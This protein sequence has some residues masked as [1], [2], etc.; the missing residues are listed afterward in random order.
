[1]DPYLGRKGVVRNLRDHL[2]EGKSAIVWGGPKIGKTTFLEQMDEALSPGI[3]PVRIDLA[4]EGTSDPVQSI[5]DGRDPVILLLDNCESLLPDPSTCI[6]R[7]RG[8]TAE[9]RRPLRGIVW[10]GAL[11]WG[12]WAMGHR[13]QF[14]SA[15]RYYPLIV[16]PPREAAVFLKQHLPEDIPSSEQKR[17]LDLTG[18]HPYLLSRRVEQKEPDCS[19]FFDD[20]WKA[21]DRPADHYVL[22][23]LMEAGSWVFLENL[24]D[25]A[26][27]KVPKETLDRLAISGLIVRT[28]VDGMAAAR[29][30]SPLIGEWVRRAAG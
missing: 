29:I 20:L 8:M 26:G 22:M 28:L 10:A 14:G 25:D 27:G 11:P 30:V 12:E 13:S 24:R 16:L 7:L 15:M 5:P 1:M 9:G 3:I 18:G 19:S 4:K 23:R 2:L 17:I 6:G 21:A